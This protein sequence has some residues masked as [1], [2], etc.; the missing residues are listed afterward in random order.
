MPGKSSKKT[1][2]ETTE[3]LEETGAG[4]PAAAPLAKK[5]NSKK[6]EHGEPP[7]GGKAKEE[8]FEAPSTLTLADLPPK[9]RQ[10][11]L[12]KQRQRLVELRDDILGQMQGIAQDSL[13]VRPE[14][15]EASGFGMHQADAGTEAY[16]K[17]FALSLL[18]Q[19][20][21]ALYEVEEAIK[22]IETGR[23]GVCEMSSKPIPLQRLEAVPHARFTVE[24]QRQVELQSRFERR[25]E[26]VPQ[27][28]EGAEATT[29][30]EEES[31]EERE[32]PGD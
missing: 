23:Y 2:K 14:G 16:D 22:R 20:Q 32:S 1:A 9:R 28:G 11:F 21:D 24:C 18:S 15:S 26:S 6:G 4:S 7:A 31:S 10:A 8:A 12:E 29:E 19:E 13:R 17:D 27:F 3:K 25:W 30:E 5:A